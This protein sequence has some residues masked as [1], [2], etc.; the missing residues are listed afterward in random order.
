MK[1]KQLLKNIPL[2]ASLQVRGSNEVNLTGIS[3]N[4]KQI[5]PGNL[6]IAKKGQRDDGAR[7]VSEAVAAGACAVVTD[8]YDPLLNTTQIIC[9]DPKSIES[10]LVANYYNYPSDELLMIGIT[11]TNGKTTTSFITKTL[12]DHLHGPCGL[13]GTIEYIVGNHR[14]EATR[15]TPDVVLNHKMLREMVI[16]GCRSAVM[17]VTS[18]ALDQGRVDEIDFDV[19]IFT[20]LTLDHLDYHH[21][22]EQYCQAKNRL[23]SEMGKSHRHKN[24]PKVAVVNTDSPWSG[25]VVEGCEVPIL[26]Y[27]IDRP[28]DLMATNIQLGGQGIQLVVS[29]QG[30]SI[31]CFWP[32]VGRF[33]VYNGLAAIGMALSQNFPLH[34]IIE[35]MADIL[36]IRGRLQPVKNA[37]GYQIFVDF[38]HSDDSLLNVLQTLKELTS[39][40]VITV[41]GC[42]GDRDATKRPKMAE[43]SEK[44]SDF[45]IVT[46]DN[47]RSENPEAICKAIIQGF[48]SRDSYFIEMDRRM[49]IKKAIEL[50]NSNDIILIA[51]KGHETYQIFSH[52]TVKFDDS[53]VAAEICAEIKRGV[54]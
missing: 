6:F 9:Q 33:N 23:F 30:E 43:A 51:G 5:A 29:Y 22:M 38:A 45:S 25:K 15:T 21:T 2:K 11:G 16:Q 54:L 36:P 20:N 32:I 49:A 13:I 44:Y 50:A 42:G 41:F 1:L 52:Q 3:A 8:V 37:L 10:L 14:Y 31:P 35:K 4:S 53:E 7:Y 40:K 12:L 17:E 27:G 46:S 39:G 26:S 47:P 34:T 18:H 24:K 19:A 48:K 28:A